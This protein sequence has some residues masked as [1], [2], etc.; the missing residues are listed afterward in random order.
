MKNLSI[1][2]TLIF[3]SLLTTPIK[4]QILPEDCKLGLANAPIIREVKLGMTLSQVEKSLGVKITLKDYKPEFT[5]EILIGVKKYY[6]NKSSDVATAVQL[7]GIDAL[8]LNFY[9]NSLYDIFVIYG[10]P[11]VMW[12]DTKE[13][14]SFLSERFDLPRNAW[15]FGDDPFF[16]LLSCN[17]FRLSASI[18]KYRERPELGLTDKK[19]N[20]LV[21]TKEKQLVEKYKSKK[22]SFEI[23]KEKGFKP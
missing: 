12:K 11:K 8:F 17:G 18:D 5:D 3:T 20:D 9:N 16:S 4:A 21:N 23:E 10:E 2:F 15:K 1:L 22:R 19:I 14:I 13:F 7:E 6:F